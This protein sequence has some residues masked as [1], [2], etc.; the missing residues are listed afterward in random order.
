MVGVLLETM[1]EGG[2][3]G[4]S[5][6]GKV[7]VGK[8]SCLV[9][10][11]NARSQSSPPCR[12]LDD[13]SL[14]NLTGLQRNT[15]RQDIATLLPPSAQPTATTFSEA[16]PSLI[17]ATEL[18]CS[19]VVFPPKWKQNFRLSRCLKETETETGGKKKKTGRK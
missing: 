2:M 13:F 15:H 7:D 18:L 16:H 9:S 11:E 10:S 17:T 19:Y 5:T 14:E 1:L 6:E 12:G 3:E 8:A 4:K